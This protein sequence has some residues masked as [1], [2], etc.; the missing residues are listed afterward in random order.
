MSAQRSQNQRLAAYQRAYNREAAAY[1]DY[2]RGG[3]PYRRAFVR[4][5]DALEE[6]RRVLN[7]PAQAAAV[8]N[9][10]VDLDE[11]RRQNPAAPSRVHVIRPDQVAGENAAGLQRMQQRMIHRHGGAEENFSDLRPFDPARGARQTRTVVI[12]AIGYYEV[13]HGQERVVGEKNHEKE[14]AFKIMNFG[15]HAELLEGVR[16]A[17]SRFKGFIEELDGDSGYKAFYPMVWLASDA[18][19]DA[20]LA[21]FVR[22]PTTIRLHA[23]IPVQYGFLKRLGVDVDSLSKRDYSMNCLTGALLKHMQTHK[24]MVRKK[25][26]EKKIAKA[27]LGDL[28]GIDYRVRGYSVD[29]AQ[30]FVNKIQKFNMYCF[31]QFGNLL[32][33]SEFKKEGASRGKMDAPPFMFVSHDAHCYVISDKVIISS[34]LQRIRRLGGGTSNMFASDK[35]A[36]QKKKLDTVVELLNR[37]RHRFTGMNHSHWIWMC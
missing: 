26:T 10:L 5:A 13:M 27:M 16:I 14:H 32:W 1:D 18:Y 22:T 20:E 23:P 24:V 21:R 30:A 37:P 29:E 33:K 28:D 3:R 9:E 35:E 17:L 8:D 4:A 12:R 6:A 31:D 34:L 15:S 7:A 11:I 19:T 25:W 2:E 36:A